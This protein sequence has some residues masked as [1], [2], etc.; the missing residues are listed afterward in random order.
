MSF[1]GR[2]RNW[3]K[4]QTASRLMRR[5]WVHFTKNEHIAARDLRLQALALYRE[6][7]NYEGVSTAAEGI[8]ETCYFLADYRN[9]VRFGWVAFRCD[10]RRGNKRGMC[11]SLALVAGATLKLSDVP[12]ALSR[13]ERSLA[14]ARELG[15]PDAIATSLGNLSQVLSATGR[16]L[17]AVECVKESLRIME[18]LGLTRVRNYVLGQNTLGLLYRDLNEEDLAQE[19]FT[20]GLYW[21]VQTGDRWAESLLLTHLSMGYWRNRQWSEALPLHRRTIAAAR[22]LNDPR[23]EVVSLH[24]IARCQME[25]GQ[26]DEAWQTV[27]WMRELADSM[28]FP[29]AQ[30]L[31]ARLM[32]RLCLKLDR[33]EE[34]KRASEEALSLTAMHGLSIGGEHVAIELARVCVALKDCT[35]AAELLE[36]AIEAGEEIREDLREVDGFRVS[37]FESHSEAYEDLQWVQVELGDYEAALVTAERGRARTLARALAQREKRVENPPDLGA[38]RRVAEELETTFVVYSVIRNPP[39]RVAEESD[40]YFFIWVVHPDRARPILYRRSG[41]LLSTLPDGHSSIAEELAGESAGPTRHF[42]EGG[43]SD[44]VESELRWLHA[45]LIEPVEAVLP[46][47]PAAIVT[48]VAMGELL[49]VPFAALPDRNGVRLIEKHTISVTPSIQTLLLTSGRPARG[50]GAL[51]VG[52]PITGLTRLRF[53]EKEAR[54]IAERLETTALTGAAATRDA[55]IAE[56]PGKRLLHFATHAVFDAREAASY[57]GALLLTGGR[58]TAEEIRQMSLD[59]EVAVLSACNTGQGRIAADGLLGLSRAFMLGG[60]PS[61]VA[62][63]WSVPDKATAILMTHFYEHFRDGKARALRLAMLHTIA[64]GYLQP[65]IGQGSF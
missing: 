60:V 58:L 38:I 48:F 24:N 23:G 33:L 27:A 45:W 64:S 42:V 53:A 44:E 11:F 18:N 43:S 30:L 40:P 29:A 65:V 9:A 32:T 14:I 63:L 5:A 31:T 59:A 41:P 1:L 46:A 55:V 12:R 6:L 51:V 15:Q 54:M 35:R 2:F 21:A 20:R 4:K 37:V 17:D 61:V 50:K 8:A 3:R 25:M 39:E 52:N 49:V 36:T 16:Y 7:R 56:M 19:T 47:D 28:H 34:A 13:V 57:Y 22:E 26:F 10:R 62:T